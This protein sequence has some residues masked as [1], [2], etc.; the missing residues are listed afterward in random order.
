MKL[1]HQYDKISDFLED[2]RF[3]GWVLQDDATNNAFWHQWLIEHPNQQERIQAAIAIIKQLNAAEQQFMPN[4]SMEDTWEKIKKDTIEKNTHSPKAKM[5]KWNWVKYAAAF[6]LFV[7]FS[8]ILY[9]NGKEQKVVVEL[10]ESEWLL[11]ENVNGIAKNIHLSDGSSV[12]LEPFSSLKYPK[13]FAGKKRNIFLEGEAFFDI[14]R[15]TTRPFFI[16]ANETITKVLGTSFTVKAFKGDSEVKVILKTGRLAVY[17]ETKAASKSHS[18]TEQMVVKADKAIYIP[19]PNKKIEIFPNQMV[20]FDRKKKE[21][22]RTIAPKP[23][24]LEHRVKLIQQ[25][26]FE[27]APIS[28]VFNAME[29]AYGIKINFDKKAL[30]KCTIST[31]LT[32]LS[33]LD[34][35]EMICRV[36]SLTYTEKDGQIFIEGKGCK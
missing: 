19:K 30:K 3:V 36:L 11:A 24:L 20:V 32:D 2:D 35:L 25:F 17:A 9:K 14:E 7:V 8:S 16:Y 31:A 26:K 15:D 1:R 27:D 22:R 10:E 6:V 34:K 5:I 13:T 21:L 28:A 18:E 12:L 29:V 4:S 33:M 23:L